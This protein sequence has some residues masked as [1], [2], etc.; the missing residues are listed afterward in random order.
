LPGTNSLAYLPRTRVTKKKKKFYKF[1]TCFCAVENKM[2]EADSRPSM[3]AY[4]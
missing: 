3:A 4:G 1:E 2:G